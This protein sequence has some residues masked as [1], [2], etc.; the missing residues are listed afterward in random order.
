LLV[1]ALVQGPDLGW[2]SPAI[3]IATAAGLLL[4]GGFVV[5]ERRSRDPLVPR[6]LL[7]NHAVSMAAVIAFMFMATFGS[8]LYFLSIYFQDVLGFD[9]LETGSAFLLPTAVVVAG[10]FL[11]GRVVTRFGIRRTLV[12][13]LTLGAIGAATAGLAIS[14]DGTYAMI[15]PGLVAVSIGDGVVFTTM[16]IAAATGVTDREQGVASGIVSTGSGIGAAVGLAILVLVA[17]FGVNGLSGEELRIA[18]AEGIRRAAFTIA[19]GI[20]MTLV[21][22]LNLRTDPDV[23]RAAPIAP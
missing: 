2:V 19:C 15:V 16:F 11:A 7:A 9:A 22:A 8:L 21:I 20:G 3:L 1:F 17:N 4:L 13:G 18:M 14:S 5:V 12:A 10:S 23:A 6:G